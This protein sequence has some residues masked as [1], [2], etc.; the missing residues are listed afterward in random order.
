L[1]LPGLINLTPA[2]LIAGLNS[3]ERQWN[4]EYGQGVINKETFI[5]PLGPTAPNPA[6]FAVVTLTIFIDGK[7]RGHGFIV[8][9]FT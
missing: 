8:I 6:E 7:K 1:A 9:R 4:V 5:A 2:N 3:V